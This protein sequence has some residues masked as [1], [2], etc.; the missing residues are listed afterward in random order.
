MINVAI[1]AIGDELLI[2]E[3]INSNSSWLGQQLTLLGMNVN[4]SV[5]IADDEEKI[6]SSINTL[7]KI[8][9]IV[10]TTGGLGPTKDDITKK[11]ISKFFNSELVED[12]ATTERLKEY[13][14]RRGR[15]MTDLH[16]EQAFIPSC[17]EAL[18]NEV[19]TAPGIFTKENNVLYFNLPGVPREMKSI[20]EDNI[21]DILNAL[22]S[23]VTE[24][25][26]VYKTIY[27]TGIV[28]SEIANRISY[29]DDENENIKFAYLPSYSGVRLR[30]GI[31]N[32]N[33]V[34]NKEIFK[35]TLQKVLGELETFVIQEN[36]P[37]LNAFVE[38]FTNNNLT[39]SVAESCTGGGLGSLLS[40][41]PGSSKIFS[42]GFIVYSNEAKMQLLEVK[43][44]TLSSYGAVSEQTAIELAEN[45]R[46]KLG[47][48]IAVSIT[49]I[50]GPDGGSDEK[51]VGTVWIGISDS[52]RTVAKKFIFLK[53]RE[54]NRE[55]SKYTALSL[56]YRNLKYNI[57][58]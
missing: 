9:D 26:F 34:L 21:I 5:V 33:L 52:N 28:E 49:G 20:F 56:I 18:K 1:I 38:H 3:T 23:E 35:N 4:H 14:S 48:D 17:S 57:E 44:N 2:G 55:L 36:L 25:Y 51:P 39:I 37:L 29:L 15:Q 13:M 19:G 53:N 11:A 10:I 16:Y 30:L 42:G 7:S 41:L 31:L 54:A 45:C 12:K 50:A 43:E 58:I 40:E 8:N 47:T 6:I 24:D 46:I 32:S 22:K 27:T